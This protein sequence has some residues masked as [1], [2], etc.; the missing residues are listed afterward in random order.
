M[1]VD[2]KELKKIVPHFSSASWGFCPIAME[3]PSEIFDPVVDP[4]T[5]REESS[6]QPGLEKADHQP[7]CQ[8]VSTLLPSLDWE[9]ISKEQKWKKA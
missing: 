2:Y 9:Q 7:Q 6:P 4:E 3:D 1:S 5:P 8:V